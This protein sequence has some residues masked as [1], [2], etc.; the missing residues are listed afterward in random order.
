MARRVP[1]MGHLAGELFK[2][3]A[4]VDMVHVPYKGGAPAMFALIA[5][6]VQLVFLVCSD[7][8][9]PGQS[10]SKIRALAVTTRKRSAH[11]PDLPTVSEAGLPVQ[12]ADN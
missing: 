9:S 10:R 1:A 11:L 4:K 2:S 8:H 3:M 7:R 5:D 6:Q 12:K